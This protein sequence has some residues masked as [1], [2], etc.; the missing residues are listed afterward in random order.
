MITE[1]EGHNSQKMRVT[2]QLVAKG[3]QEEDKELSDSPTSQRESLRLFLA[4]ASMI[5]V[6]SLRLIDILA[7]YLQGE[8]LKRDVFLEVSK[9]IWAEGKVWKLKKPQ[10]G[11]TEAGRCF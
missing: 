8:E 7:A 9:D 3:F 2:A 11:L 4:V 5:K 10:Y 6:Q 1:K